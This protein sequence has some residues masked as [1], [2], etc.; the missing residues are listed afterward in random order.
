[1]T[2][3]KKV[4]ICGA[5]GFIGRN[6]WDAL[7]LRDDLEVWGTYRTRRFVDSPNLIP[8][9]L[10]DR[11]VV[12]TLTRGV[13]VLIQTAAV[14]SGAKDIVTRPYIH[15][16]DNVVMNSFLLQAAYDQQVG[17][18][19]FFSCTLMYPSDT[20]VPVKETDVDLNA[21]LQGSYFGGAWMKI[22]V[23]K[24]CEFYSRLGR[25]RFTVIRHSNIYGPYDKYDLEKSHVFGATVAKVMTSPEKVTVWGNGEEERDLLYVSDLVRFVGLAMEKQETPFDIFNVGYGRAIAIRDLVEKIVRASGRNLGIEYDVSKPT[26]PTRLWVDISKAK[27]Q[28]GWEPTVSLEEGIE[29]TLA[30]YSRN[31]L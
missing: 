4:L 19:I 25:S 6:I 29:K 1:M 17:Q 21:S 28:M 11:A 20:G 13:D 22:F 23:E 12:A 16:T 5:S 30:W 9:D 7:S 10:T 18:V 24:L 8:A 15:V 3:K 26:I 14:T 2:K 31:V 27:S